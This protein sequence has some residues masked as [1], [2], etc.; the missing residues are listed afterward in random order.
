MGRHWVKTTGHTVG[1]PP[2]GEHLVNVG[3]HCVTTTGHSVG[4]LPTHSVGRGGHCVSTTGHPVGK[5]AFGPTDL[6]ATG[7]GCGGPRRGFLRG[8]RPGPP[9]PPR[10]QGGRCGSAIARAAR[11]RL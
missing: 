7:G 1:V 9:Q 3:G 8:P 11:T 6:V 5:P 10:S 4:T 2:V